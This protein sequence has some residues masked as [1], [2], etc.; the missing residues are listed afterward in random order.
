MY[1]YKAEFS[2]NCMMATVFCCLYNVKAPH[3]ISLYFLNEK[4]S[5]RFPQVVWM[6]ITHVVSLITPSFPIR[7]FYFQ[8]ESNE[9]CGESE[10]ENF[11]R[12]WNLK[13]PYSWAFKLIIP[14]CIKVKQNVTN[15]H[16]T[17]NSYNASSKLY[18]RTWYA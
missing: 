3:C 2:K 6:F 18:K 17:V 15:F 14:I 16:D 8:N 13:H 7:Q 12:R 9:L 5:F 11:Q 1:I 10:C 4:L